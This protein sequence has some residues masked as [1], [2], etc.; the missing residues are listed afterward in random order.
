MFFLFGI[1]YTANPFVNVYVVG[2]LLIL[3]S[4]IILLSTNVLVKDR[5]HFRQLEEIQRHHDSVTGLPKHAA[6]VDSCGKSTGK[7]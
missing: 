7:K 6:F 5:E 1:V 2:T 3:C 4:A